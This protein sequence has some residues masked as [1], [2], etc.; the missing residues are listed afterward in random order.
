MSESAAPIDSCSYELDDGAPVNE[1][2]CTSEMGEPT[3]GPRPGDGLTQRR[4][5]GDISQQWADFYAPQTEDKAAAGGTPKRPAGTR[6]SPTRGPGSAA[7]RLWSSE[8]PPLPRPGLGTNRVA[9][10]LAAAGGRQPAPQESAGSPTRHRPGGALP[11][12]PSLDSNGAPLGPPPQAA[13]VWDRTGSNSFTSQ[14][15]HGSG[16]GSAGGS[17]GG[18]PASLDGRP[19]PGPSA[20]L[21]VPLPMELEAAAPGAISRANSASLPP[22]LVPEGNENGGAVVAG[23]AVGGPPSR[24]N[25]GGSAANVAPPSPFPHLENQPGRPPHDHSNVPF[26]ALLGGSVS[27]TSSGSR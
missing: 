12:I 18:S 4:P 6:F 24:A 7:K 9:T 16:G 10:A 3:P 11:R 17:V 25:S 15:S 20:L 22:Q 21:P 2:L 1:L 8:L 23:A 5:F 14:R 27:F 13:P 26:R 19:G